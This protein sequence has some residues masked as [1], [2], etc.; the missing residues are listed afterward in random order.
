MAADLSA[1]S[2]CGQQV[3]KFDNDRFLA[4]LFAPADRREALFALFAFN[5]EIARTREVVREP[6]MGQIRLQWWRDGIAAADAATPPHH[7]VLEPLSLAMQRFKLP[8][9]A[10]DRLI[11]ARE[12]DLEPE[13]PADLAALLSY[14]EATT[15]P[16]FELALI[17]LGAPAL[18]PPAPGSD[19]ALAEVA[20]L[21]GVAY[22][23]TGIV[24]AVVFHARQHR[25]LL[26]ETLLNRH[27]V[28]RSVLFD[29]KPQPGLRAVTRELVAVAGDHLTRAR[30]RRRAIPRA[31]RPAL[32]PLA[33]TALHLATL[34]RHDC[35]PFA[36]RVLMPHP[37]RALWLA[38][39]ALRGRY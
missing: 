24:R 15:A 11:D 38:G 27:D 3:R 22:G 9:A 19:D 35:D 21:A 33:A 2:Y 1:L 30:G 23:V 37:W 28:R 32:L 39:A 20:R 10:F 34:R 13:P 16:L 4:C 26:P 14:A 7:E 18:G 8:R 29:L 36:A 25:L 12:I 31:A 6:I 17:I 5:L